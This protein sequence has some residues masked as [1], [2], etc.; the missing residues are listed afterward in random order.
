MKMKQRIGI[1]IELQSENSVGLN[2]PV[3]L[4]L[5]FYVFYITLLFYLAFLFFFR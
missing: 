1:M 4:T 3:L 5:L 2:I